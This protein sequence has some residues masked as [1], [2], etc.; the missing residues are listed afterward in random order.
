MPTHYAVLSDGERVYGEN[1]I[2]LPRSD[3]E[4]QNPYNDEGLVE[5]W[6]TAA[7]LWEY[8]IT[9][10]LTGARPTAPSKNGLNDAEDANGDVNMDESMEQ[11]QEEQDRALSEYP[12]LMSEPG[13]SPPKDRE[14]TMEIAME[15]WDVPAFFLAKN[16]QLAA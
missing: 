16:G 1:A 8:S 3:V 14:R 15:D 13:W 5:D 2:H 11:M 7:K 12:L 6:D 10:R 4:I 9:S